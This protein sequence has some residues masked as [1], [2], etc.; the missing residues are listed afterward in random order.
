LRAK[1]AIGAWQ[2][3]QA[4]LGQEPGTFFIGGIVPYWRTISTPNGASYQWMHSCLK[5]IDRLKDAIVLECLI[6]I[7]LDEMEQMATEVIR[8]ET[9]ELR[10]A[11]VECRGIRRERLARTIIPSSRREIRLLP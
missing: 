2:F 4:G 5:T 3:S 11:V 1:L 7:G 10:V 9:E 6:R 8:V